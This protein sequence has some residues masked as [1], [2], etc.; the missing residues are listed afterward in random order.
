MSCS[1]S[2]CWSVSVKHLSFCILY[3]GSLPV[4]WLK[5]GTERQRYQENAAVWCTTE[6]MC[7]IMWIISC[8]FGWFDVF[9]TIWLTKNK[10]INVLTWFGC[11]ENPDWLEH[12]SPGFSDATLLIQFQWLGQIVNAPYKSWAS[13]REDSSSVL[14]EADEPRPLSFNTDLEFMAA[15]VQRLQLALEGAVL[16]VQRVFITVS[17]GL[18]HFYC[19]LNVTQSLKKQMRQSENI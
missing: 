17:T 16:S 19:Y 13:I 5:V 10:Q 6:T 1:C 7:I 9:G 3:S 15:G 4:W 14:V 8:W 12:T 18:N 2:A 11:F